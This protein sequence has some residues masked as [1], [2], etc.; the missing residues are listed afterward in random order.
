MPTGPFVPKFP[1]VV[2]GGPQP[3]TPHE[4]GSRTLSIYGQLKFATRENYVQA[5]Y[6]TTVEDHDSV[7]AYANNGGA[8]SWLDY[9]GTLHGTWVA[10]H[11]GISTSDRSLK[12]NI[13]P[14]RQTLKEGHPD[15]LR[16]LRP[17]SYTYKGSSEEAKHTRF[18]FIA[19]EMNRT[20]PQITRS[21]PRKDESRLGLVYQD[22]L[23]FLTAM[24]QGLAQDMATL[25][26]RLASIEGRIAQ[27]KRWKKEKRARGR[28]GT[29]SAAVPATPVGY[30]P[31]GSVV[32]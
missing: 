2:T 10:D 26:P 20:L 3:T 17:V 24:L 12:E 28:T 5:E 1:A 21:L 32:V 30:R 9:G 14:L 19:D 13:K 27:R 18:G 8:I 16:E 6:N 29:S 22:L 11:P 23:A 7:K 25:A 15:I 4:R 31:D